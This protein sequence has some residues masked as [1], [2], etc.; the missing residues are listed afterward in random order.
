MRVHAK[1]STAGSTQHKTAVG[2][3]LLVALA[4]TLLGVTPAFAATVT[5]RPL[6]F[7]FDGSD[8][9]AGRF[10]QPVALDVDQ[11]T[12]IVYVIDSGRNVLDKFDA[13]GVAQSFSATGS[14]SLAP[15][16]SSGAFNSYSD[17]AVDN[18]GPNAGR[19]H[20][21]REFGPLEAFTAAGESLWEL[22]GFDDV[23]G[24]A[25]DTDG[26]LWVGDYTNSK[27]REYASSG[28][29][30]S[31][32][33]SVDTL[34]RSCRLDVDASG[35]LY[36]NVYNGGVDKY[37][38][39]V[40]GP[41][42]DATTT[43][44]VTVDQSSASGHIFTIHSTDFNEYDSSGT[45][46]G[47]F[48]SELLSR[49]FGIA[50]N[51]S[52]D[53]VYVA[54]SGSGTVKVFGPPV[55]GTVPDVTI[56]PTTAIEV[57]KATFN[58]KVNPQS[59]PNSYFFQWKR[60][61]QGWSE[62]AAS[63]PQTLPED[64]SDHAVAV[65]VT[66]LAGNTTY[67]ARLVGL[68]TE[69]GL[70]SVSNEVT[71]T[72][73]APSAPAVTIDD[74]TSVGTTSAD[75][76]GTVNP[77]GD[78]GTTW[79]VQLSTDPACAS[80]F[81]NQASHSLESEASSPQPVTEELTGL[82]PNQRYCVRISAS[83]GGGTTNSEVKELTTD[84]I[85]PTEVETAFAA[86]RTDTT[87][88]LNARVNPQGAGDAHPLV[89]RFEYSEDD[90]ASWIVLP[91]RE[92]SGGAR[93]QIVVGDE[94]TGLTPNTTYSYRFSAEND[95]GPASP[96][97]AVKTFTTR[98][99]AEVT[100]PARGIELVN[101]PDKGNQNALSGV[102]ML[103]L[104]QLTARPPGISLDGEK[105]TWGVSGGAPG[106]PNGTVSTFLAERTPSG[107]QSRSLAPPASQQ[108]GGGDLFYIARAA[109]PDFSRFVF[110]AEYKPA[111]GEASESTRLRLDAHQHQDILQT[112]NWT[113]ENDGPGSFDMTEDGAHVID[114]NHASD[115][116]EEIG[117]GSG[118]VLSIM[119]DGTQSSCGLEEGPSF[120]GGS[121]DLTGRA[122]STL[123]R[124]GYHA[125]ATTDASRVYF[126]AKPNGECGESWGLYVRNRESEETT[127]IDAG[128]AT[129]DVGFITATPNGRAAY[130]ASFSQLDPADGNEGA[131]LY[132]WEEQSEESSCL[133]CVVA[134]ASL[135]TLPIEGSQ[136][137]RPILISPDFSHA[138]FESHEEL[139]AGHPLEASERNVYVLSDGQIRFVT[140]NGDFV[141]GLL[142]KN[143]S[144]ISA[145]GNML[146]FANTAQPFY[147]ADT[148]A[149]NLRQAYLYDDREAS[150]E[151]VS[152][153]R[154]GAT[155][156]PVAPLGVGEL[157]E[158]SADGSTLVFV[159]AEGLGPLD[160][161]RTED[162]YEWRGGVRRLITDGVTEYPASILS[163][164][165]VQGI[166]AE[167]SNILFSV[168]DPGLTGH[169]RDGVS[170]LYVARI[171]G[172]FPRPTEPVHCDGD[173]CQ[174][175]LVAPPVPGGAGSASFSG[176]GNVAGKPKAR[177]KKGRV[178]RKGRCVK[179]RANQ[180]HHERAS[181]TKQGRTK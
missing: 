80:G 84:P 64:S 57:N 3:A 135:A 166:D 45:L 109:T 137:Y 34:E 32:I 46:L 61:F 99:V 73:A 35:N 89:Y 2:L 87:A 170:N 140:K 79:R 16:F 44:A 126:E 81:S 94:L 19:I 102:T 6:L 36:A 136:M 153:N 119:P 163:A 54:D 59:V 8:T 53:R 121:R 71:F 14:S 154:E 165:I 40:K 75:I 156:H 176:R 147:T 107:W 175:P 39:G 167:G 115:Q 4:A 152:C 12:G 160:V 168:T 150:L 82:L 138:Y 134:N 177:C 127:L 128:T 68:N 97:G 105:A 117:D 62:A 124:E 96:Q 125:I 74:P 65:N 21:M 114:I 131:D 48:G 151:C 33:G 63:A 5:D 133:T 9:T 30:P 58:G 41:T 129:Q 158:M 104:S 142:F 31:E 47:T 106:A 76:S 43:Q 146:A 143:T 130:F 25:V 144:R 17:V 42:L 95:A 72:T 20:V 111:F 100:L 172:G 51:A 26:H 101:N 50:Y 113:T 83:N 120:A 22:G 132:R 52:L 148:T 149:G 24:L 155:T 178:R 139:V 86:P 38:G 49:G 173:A 123:W 66:G 23:C 88:R 55:T 98:T 70:R 13:A 108:V 159:S 93:S 116:L 157:L 169:E 162:V 27:A 112:Y 179:R 29:P 181:Q 37:E 122:A 78:F 103:S 15:G 18:Y 164:P 161:N 60:S 174:G 180:R 1:A 118:E 7:S 28:S 10:S 11:S 69:T 171:G 145:D 92:Y 77:Q 90:G 91:D 141:S 67:Q 56:E 85:A 110:D